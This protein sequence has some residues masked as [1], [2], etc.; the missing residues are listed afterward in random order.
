MATKIVRN[1]ELKDW[2]QALG[3]DTDRATRV[4][5]DLKVNDVPRIYIEEFGS[6]SVI[7][8]LPPRML[9]A[10]VTTCGVPVESRS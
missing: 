10:E 3:V 1:E 2:L 7:D 9:G 5:L 8:V 6:E 4:V